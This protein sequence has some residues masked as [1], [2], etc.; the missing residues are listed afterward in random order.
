[1]IKQP[2][3]SVVIP[4]YNGESYIED[5]IRSVQLQTM[6]EL[7]IIVVDDASTDGTPVLVANICQQDNRVRLIRNEY[8][9]GV[10]EAR[11]QGVG[12]AQAD[13]VAFLD[14]DDAWLPEKLEKQFTFQQN[15]DAR[16]LYTG[17]TCMDSA[18]RDIGRSFRPPVR[19]SSEDLLIGNEIVC[20]TVLVEKALL[21]AHPMTQSCLHEDFICWLQILRDIG[22][23]YGLPEALI[24]YRFAAHS[25]SRNK[26]KSAIMTWKSYAYLG[27]PFLR[28]CRY[29]VLYAL[30]GIKRYFV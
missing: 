10:A 14:C 9:Q 1:M 21:A 11:N 19:V 13:W 7:E 22:E 29:F 27:I 4:V 26:W 30:H 24:R 3:C 8:N 20:S 2:I 15:S 28:R 6:R 25:K 23:A 18:G 12:Q 5:C 16:M 17:A